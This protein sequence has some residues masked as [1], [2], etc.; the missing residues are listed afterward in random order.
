MRIGFNLISRKKLGRSQVPI[1]TVL[2][3][4]GAEG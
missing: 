4:W 2:G 3:E 1:D